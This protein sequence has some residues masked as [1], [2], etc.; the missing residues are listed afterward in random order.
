MRTPSDCR[1]CRDD[2]P[3]PFAFTMAF[4]PIVDLARR[5]VWGYEALVRG[6]AGEPA[7]TILSRITGDTVYRFDQLARVRAIEL[8]AG[9]FR[10]DPEARL[11]VNFLP[12]AIYEP[13]ACLRR[14][15]DAARRVGFPPDRIV[16]EFTERERLR[17]PGHVARIVAAHRHHGFLTALDDFGAGYAGLSL[18]ADFRT[19]L[20][21]IDMGLIR[22]LDA[23]PMRA[24][25]VATL[26]DLGRRLGIAVIA[27]GVETDAEVAALREAGATLFQGYR[28]ARPLVEGLPAID[29]P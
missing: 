2:G 27:E 11:S 14:S 24:A 20:I 26:F 9:L 25:I 3:F 6:P 4:Q 10:D 23:D 15:L 5:R 17:D 1:A 19:D 29:W 7:A 12:N 18:L 22:G 8:A 28:F 16:F 21:K 13:I